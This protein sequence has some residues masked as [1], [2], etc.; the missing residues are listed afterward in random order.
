MRYFHN[1]S[2]ND[3]VTLLDKYK[4]NGLEKSNV[5]MGNRNF[6]RWQGA[7]MD[8]MAIISGGLTTPAGKRTSRVVTVK[9]STS[10]K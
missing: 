7:T 10:P 2:K 9:F 6:G 5:S 3:W 4:N 8:C 1:F